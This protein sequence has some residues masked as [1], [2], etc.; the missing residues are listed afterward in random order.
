MHFLQH[1]K[2]KKD[3]D[4]ALVYRLAHICINNKPTGVFSQDFPLPRGYL[5]T[6]LAV[7]LCPKAH[8]K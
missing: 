1:I 7:S 8:M 3:K 6:A 5:D 4:I 2:Q